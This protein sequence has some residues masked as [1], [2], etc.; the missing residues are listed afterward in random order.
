M[1]NK[2]VT[3]I[4][5]YTTKQLTKLLIVSVVN[6]IVV[7]TKVIPWVLANRQAIKTIIQYI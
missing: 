1:I 3:Q 5:G 7:T 2:Q 6:G 4:V